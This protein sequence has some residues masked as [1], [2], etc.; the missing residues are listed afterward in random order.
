MTLMRWPWLSGYFLYRRSVM[1]I[2]ILFIIWS[3]INMAHGH[4]NITTKKPNLSSSGVDLTLIRW[5]LSLS[6]RERLLHLQNHVQ[7]IL[8]I[9]N[10]NATI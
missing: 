8:K 6:P 3:L 1:D 4:K 10:A 7:A 9:R 2:L 5:S